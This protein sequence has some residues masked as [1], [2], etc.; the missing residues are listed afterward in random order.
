VVAGGG[1]KFSRRAVLIAGAAGLCGLTNGLSSADDFAPYYPSREHDQPD[2]PNLRFQGFHSPRNICPFVDDLPILP[3]RRLGGQIV[4][5]ESMHQFHRDMPAAPSWGFDG[6]THLGP[7]I[8]VQRGE[9][10]K[11]TFVN[12]LGSHI[13]AEYI[14]KSLHGVSPEDTDR[15][16]MVIHLHG[17]PNTPANDGYPT[18]VMRPGSSIDYV[19]NNDL[20]ATT[21]WYHDHSMG[22]T[23][24][25]VYAG[26]AAQYWV[27]DKFDTGKVDNPL[28]LPAD[29]YELPLL[30]SD[31]VFTRDGRLRYNAIRTQVFD[32]H[33]SGGMGGDVMVVNGK[34]WPNMMVDRG[35]YRIRL[36]SASS[37]SDYRIAFSNNMPF[38]VIGSDGGLLDR[39][40]EVLAL[41]VVS[42]ER[43]D[44]L[45]DFTGF[46]PG[47]SVELLN[48]MQINWIGQLGGSARVGNIMRFT[49]A[50]D[51]G[52]YT[53]IPSTLRGGRK[54]PQRLP[55]LAAMTEPAVNHTMNANFNREGEWIARLNMNI[56]NLGFDSPYIDIAR[57]GSVQQ[58]N[59]IN[60]DVTQQNHAIH[61]HL[62]QFR[63]IGRQNFD[64]LRYAH[65]L[66][67]PGHI[68]DCRWA[69]S[70]DP[71]VTGPME[72]PAP[73]EQGWKDTVR[74]PRGQITRVLVRWR[75]ADELGFDPDAPFSAPDGAPLQ[76]Y[77][78]HCHMLD[79]ED[80]EMM[81]RIRIVKAD[82][83]DEPAP[84]SGMPMMP[85]HAHH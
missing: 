1:R 12:N 82:L 51:V 54:Q 60:A 69:P 75:T 16:P 9:A 65:E 6:L 44:L 73:Y 79:H 52:R 50:D 27:R 55:A 85:G 61:L 57:Q 45:V 35:V 49:A 28:G 83:P 70:A 11:T 74:C 84:D 34:V 41:D 14:D 22:I 37:V 80:N 53:Q 3:R 64:R 66:D 38:W 13:L 30:L 39:P 47:D 46:Q 10:T 77:V 26:L 31:K 25:N 67:S 48:T 29:E 21:L 42:A 71:Y 36:T 72:D 19:F 15:P 2:L 43:Y 56:D 32:H 63:V 59:L 4:A 18:A 8:E 17:A 33:W 78:W 68:D 23:R 5:A 62:A 81:R 40:V 24:L 76:G 7:V 20:E 58:W